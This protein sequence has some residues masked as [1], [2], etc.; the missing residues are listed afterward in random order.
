MVRTRRPGRL[1]RLLLKA[2]VLIFRWHLGFLLGRRFLLVTHVGRRSGQTYQTVVEVVGSRGR[3]WYVMSG[4]G[5]TSDWYLNV[6]EAGTAEVGVGRGA[7]RVKVR[8]LD[9]AAAVDVIAAY[10]RRNRLIA[11]VI[12]RALSR[13][14][15]WRYTGTDSERGR[16]VSQLPIL[17]FDAED[18]PAVA[19]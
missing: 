5:R 17:E 1:A 13:Q 9:T 2:P 6:R 15:G 14:V 10:E 4:F 8:E 7:S 11:P 16:L 12:R 18:H 19:D 3:R